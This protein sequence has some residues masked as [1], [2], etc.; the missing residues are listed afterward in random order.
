MALASRTAPPPRNA[1]AR[2]QATAAATRLGL[3]GLD[4]DTIAE[5]LDSNGCAVVGPLLPAF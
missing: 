5:E 4:W 2:A 3:A 1:K